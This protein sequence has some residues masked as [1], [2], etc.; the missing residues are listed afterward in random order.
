MAAEEA[1]TAA[2]ID[3]DAALVERAVRGERRAFDELVRRH[4]PGLWRLVRRYLAD[5]ADASDVTQLA[6]VRAY[7]GLAR[8]RGDATVRSWLYRIGINLALNHRRDRARE[9]PAEI[10]PDQLTTPAAAPALMLA[11]ERSLVVRAAVAALPPKQRLV[12]ELR[13][14]DDL[15]FR[16]VAMLAECTENAAK[17]SFHYAVKRLREVLAGRGFDQLAASLITGEDT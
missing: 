15:P 10:A 7:R 1:V 16:E 17:V 2:P 3:L 11:A 6:F 9:Q 14:Y 5:D 4:Q 12:L 8:F 13:V